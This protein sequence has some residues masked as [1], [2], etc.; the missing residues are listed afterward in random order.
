MSLFGPPNIEKLLA[1]RDVDGIIKALSYDKDPT[2]SHAAAHALGQ[3]GDPQAVEPLT[4]ALKN[5]DPVLRAASIAALT[6]F[7]QPTTLPPIIGALQDKDPA[8][9]KAAILALGTL[10]NEETIEPLLEVFTKQTTE[11]YPDT[12]QALVKIAAKVDETTR[13]EQIIQ[14][15]GALLAKE[16][17]ATCA[18][19]IEALQKMGWKPDASAIAATYY[20]LQHQWDRCVAI[21][22]PAAD[23][24]IASLAHEDQQ[25]R[26]A[27]FQAL[28]QIGVPV[29]DG[30]IA[31]LNH[32]NHEVQQAAFWALVKIGMPIMENLIAVLQ[33]DNET[34]R[35]S[36]A[37]ALGHLG[38]PQAVIPLISL[39]N[40]V[41]WSVR[42]DAYKAVI[43]IGKPALPQLLAALTHESGEVRWGAA[44][45]LEALGWKPGQDDIGARYWI[46]KGEWHKCIAI[47][48]PAIPPLI[49]SL[50]HWDTNVCKEAMGSLIHIGKP[51]VEPL[52]QTLQSVEKPSV[53]KCTITALGMIGDKRPLDMLREI[54][55]DRDKEVSQAASEAISAI[56]T[57]EV[58]RG[59]S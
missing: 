26:Q 31:A 9:H 17:Q 44:G 50:G 35:R 16:D 36:C 25:V 13:N 47:G 29:A 56:E 32:T 22:A 48:E 27:S 58:W 57:G 24:L 14:P 42:R 10:G 34:I 55:S 23:A 20:A 15:L 37:T 12:L 8:V 2:I 46:V 33:D 54:L 43:K 38:N 28:I 45:T 5:P 59:K 40:D 1:K 49:E 41:D 30:L 39:F 53:R 52:M 19:I 4:I 7:A 6:R 18:A 3:I 11:Y 21:G 51:S